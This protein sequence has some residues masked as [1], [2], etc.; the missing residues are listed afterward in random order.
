MEPLTTA[1]LPLAV[2][3]AVLTVDHTTVGQFMISR[4]LVAGTLTGW[5]LG[6]P[7]TGFALGILLELYLLVEFPVGGARYPEGAPATVVAVAAATSTALPGAEALGVAVGLVWGQLGGLTVTGLRKVT[8]RVAP[9]PGDAEM[10]P[11]HVVTAHLAGIAMDAARGAL[12]TVA[13]VL[14][15]RVVVR[16]LGG[17]WPLDPAQTRSLLLL[18]A[19]VSLGILLRTFGGFRARAALFLGG[20]AG[21]LALG[22]VL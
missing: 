14:V 5:L 1:L 3:G 20:L 10:T 22:W 19:V 8:A 17:L 12:L 11:S 16:G 6:D 7:A 15:G 9:A 4:P 2:L 13:G 21:G 18:G